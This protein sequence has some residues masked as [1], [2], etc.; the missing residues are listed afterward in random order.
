MSEDIKTVPIER[1]EPEQSIKAE[2]ST[3]TEESTKAEE[4][5]KIEESIKTETSTRAEATT[6]SEERTR[7]HVKK[8]KVKRIRRGV[9]ALLITGLIGFGFWAY[10]WINRVQPAFSSIVYELGDEISHNPEDYV[11]GPERIVEQGELD[12]SQVDRS[13]TGTY[14]V[15]MRCGKSEFQYEVIIQDTTAPT[16]LLRN[17][18][19]CLAL[20]REYPVEELVR[21]V[22]DADSFVTLH[23][24]DVSGLLETVSYHN[25]GTFVCIVVAEDTSGNRASVSVPVT[26]GEAPVISG[27]RDIYVALGSQVDYLEEVTAWDG[28]DGNLTGRITVDDGEVEL[29]REGTYKLTYRVENDLGIDTVSCV[30]VTVASAEELQE[31]IGSRKVNR[32]SAKIIGAI[33]PYDAGASEQ[34]SIS[35]TLEY[36]RPAL[37]QLYHAEGRGY[38]AGSGYIMEITEDTVYICSNRHVVEVYDSWD[39]YFFDGTRVRGRT[40]GYS[41]L[42]DVGVASVSVSD[43]PEEL[44]EQLMTI[45]IDKEYWSGLDDQRIDVGLERVDRM[46]GILHTS[47]GI[48]LKVK[49][50]FGWY[51]RENHTEVTLVLEHGDSGSAVMDGYGNLIG[52]A[53]AYTCSPR[54]YWCVP[55]D[56]I[57]E[58]YKEITGREVYT[59]SR[60]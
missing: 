6:T 19:V 31:L 22:E 50:Y 18:P 9:F 33:N 5:T 17:E 52:M 24:Q 13:R 37:V 56:G 36:M 21:R 15:F 35:D 30:D 40:L 49:Q 44:M 45:H 41:D 23:V 38:T 3:K 59:Y 10:M 1:I 2:E 60:K 20:D 47:T 46:G 54:R 53:F 55:L 57:L 32:T 42:F 25:T 11:L 8:R 29:T 58:S 48:M 43:V 7:A 14:Q 12:L 51:D 4:S 28:K 34:D 16:I 27:V 39:V 26:V